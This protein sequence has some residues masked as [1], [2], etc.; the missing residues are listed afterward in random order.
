MTSKAIGDIAQAFEEEGLELSAITIDIDS[1]IG[2]YK[3]L[4]LTFYDDPSEERVDNVLLKHYNVP[5]DRR[6]EKFDGEADCFLAWIEYEDSD[7]D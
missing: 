6:A 4:W 2:I 3:C 7:R 5:F 1:S